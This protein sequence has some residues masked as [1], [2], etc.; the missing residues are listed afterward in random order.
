MLR[1]A[2]DKKNAFLYTMVVG[3][4]IVANIFRAFPGTLETFGGSQGSQDEFLDTYNDHGPGVSC[5]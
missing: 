4:T 3:V 5:S 2:F 1:V